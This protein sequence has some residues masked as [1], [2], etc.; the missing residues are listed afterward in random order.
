MTIKLDNQITDDNLKIPGYIIRQ[1]DRTDNHAGGPGMY[2]SEAIIHRRADKLEFSEIDLLWIELKIDQKKIFVGACYRPP[3]S[4]TG[5]K[6]TFH[7]QA[8]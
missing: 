5:G 4:V 8:K 3:R 1:K 2:I 7:I 6:Q